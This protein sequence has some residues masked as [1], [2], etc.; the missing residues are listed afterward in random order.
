MGEMVIFTDEPPAL[1]PR[2][3]KR[4]VVVFAGEDGVA[5]GG[6]AYTSLEAALA[7]YLE[8]PENVVCEWMLIMRQTEQAISRRQA[9]R[10]EA[11]GQALDC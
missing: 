8:I 5:G 9:I 7:D 10:E 4:V 11:G 6:G 3:V 2:Q 1:P